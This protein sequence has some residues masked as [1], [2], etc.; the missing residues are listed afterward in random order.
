[1]SAQFSDELQFENAGDAGDESSP[2]EGVDIAPTTIET[3]S[4]EFGL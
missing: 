4:L 3:R 2:E 1:M